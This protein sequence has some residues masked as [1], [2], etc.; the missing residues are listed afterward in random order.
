MFILDRSINAILDVYRV[1]LPIEN[2]GRIGFNFGRRESG[3]FGLRWHLA[4]KDMKL[5]W[6]GLFY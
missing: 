1:D 3:T 2:G 5:Q 4:C 6:I